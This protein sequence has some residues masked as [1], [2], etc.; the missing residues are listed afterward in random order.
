MFSASI[1]LKNARE[2]KELELAEVS[3]KLKVPL[4]Y[5]QAIESE[6]RN[7]YPQEPY[8]SLIIKD[9]ANFLGLNGDDI[10]SL[11]RRDF[12]S[13]TNQKPITA[14]NINLTPHFAFRVATIASIIIF[15]V[16][17]TLEYFKFN[18]PPTLKMSWP[19]NLTNNT[20]E[21]SGTTDSESTVRVNDD[22]VVVD[23]SGNFR[24]K[25]IISVDEQKI[26]VQSKSPSG[27]TSIAEKTYRRQ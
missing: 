20:L 22:L 9:Y 21:V 24:K 19:E 23:S 14:Q 10:L 18:R 13:K 7:T 17:L 8:C 12:A 11:F 25:I 27:Q 2:D 3:K 26:V 5:L 1:I 6:N 4:K 15:A 16:Y